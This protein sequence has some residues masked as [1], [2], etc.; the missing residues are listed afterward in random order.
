MNSSDKIINEQ[1]VSDF[2]SLVQAVNG[3]G[4]V[5]EVAERVPPRARMVAGRRRVNG[6]RTRELRALVCWE[7]VRR[8]TSYLSTRLARMFV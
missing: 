3:L 4:N 8:G 5:T 2:R 1:L 6:V 7:T